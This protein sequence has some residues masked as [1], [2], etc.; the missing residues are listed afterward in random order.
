MHPF[1]AYCLLCLTKTLLRACQRDPHDITSICDLEFLAAMYRIMFFRHPFTRLILDE[2]FSEIHH[3]VF[4][5]DTATDDIAGMT[6]QLPYDRNSLVSNLAEDQI[7]V[8]RIH[9]KSQLRDEC[10]TE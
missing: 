4:T 1:I 2:I 9:V 7:K 3:S 5:D 6:S 8:F 10:S